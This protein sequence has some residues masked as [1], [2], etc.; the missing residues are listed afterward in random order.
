MKYI[1]A[2]LN[3]GRMLAPTDDPLVAD[4][5][6]N[7]ERINALAEQS[8]GFVW[9]YQDETGNAT[10]TRPYDDPSIL[11]NFSVWESREALFNF[12]Y[13][14]EHVEFFRRRR[15][16]FEKMEQA[17]L[18]LWWIPEGHLPTIEEAKERLAH[19]QAHG[20]TPYAFT[21]KQYFEPETA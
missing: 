7:L 16:W 18:V 12:T 21:F 3:I 2:Q 10:D 14:S 9:R 5:M 11:I 15:E 8:P 4:F 17:Y 1:L 13:Q 6:N 20:A 19:L